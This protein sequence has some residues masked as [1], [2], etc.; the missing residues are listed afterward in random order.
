MYICICMYV[1]MYIHVYIGLTLTYIYACMRLCIVLTPTSI[2]TWYEAGPAKRRGKSNVRLNLGLVVS[3][4]SMYLPKPAPTRPLS[5]RG[6][7]FL[8]LENA[9]AADICIAMGQRCL[10]RRDLLYI[11]RYAY[12]Q[13]ICRYFYRVTG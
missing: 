8:S 12:T 5:L 2:A 11:H 7:R 3:D 10:P 6:K 1:C 13:L 9:V 4:I